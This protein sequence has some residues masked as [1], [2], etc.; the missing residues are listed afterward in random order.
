MYCLSS[1][2]ETEDEN[3]EKK[4]THAFRVYDA[5][6]YNQLGS[7]DLAAYADDVAID[8]RDLTAAFVVWSTDRENDLKEVK[9]ADIGG[10][11]VKE[12]EDEE[13]EEEES[14]FASDIDINDG[15]ILDSI[16]SIYLN[17]SV[18]NFSNSIGFQLDRIVIFHYQ[19][20][21]TLKNLIGQWST[22]QTANGKQKIRMTIY[23]MNYQI[24]QISYKA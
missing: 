22:I 24:I 9:L 17:F 8:D 19:Q 5:K 10:V 13:N 7:I 23:A 11:T 4:K 14:E 21:V 20:T 6:Y 3:E 16:S 15:N 18:I 1:S 12:E 2:C